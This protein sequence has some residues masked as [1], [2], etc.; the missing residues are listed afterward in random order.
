MNRWVSRM[1]VTNAPT[2]NSPV[3]IRAPSVDDPEPADDE[4]D[5]E[6]D[7][8]EEPQRREERDPR[9]DGVPVGVE[10]VA[11]GVLDALGLVGLGVRGLDD[12]DA[13]EVV[14]E[15]GVQRADGGPNL[16][17]L[18]L[19]GLYETVGE[20]R[21]EG[22]GEQRDERQLPVE[23]GED[24]RDGEHHHQQPEE[25]VHPVVEERLQPVDVVREHGHHLAGLLVGE[26]GHVEPLHPVVGVGPDGVL[27]VLGEGVPPPVP[28]PVERRAAEEARDDQPRGEPEL[29]AG[30]CREPGPRHQRQVEGLRP[31]D[32]RV[33]GD[34]EEQ[35]REQVEHPGGHARGQPDGEVARVG[36]AVLGEQPEHRV[37]HPLPLV[38]E[39]VLAHV[40]LC[41]CHC[42][43]RARDAR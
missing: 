20:V 16:G 17:V 2:E 19:D 8:R 5:H 7:P 39:G 31:L 14:L 9:R 10:V 33:D 40:D 41:G 36:P 4:R 34:A 29:R 35:W 1:K 18:R 25:G 30:V 42:L 38:L 28:A 24:R 26:E 22:D 32:D 12:A 13:A 21:D 11:G 15:P 6:A 3:K 43:L 23:V 37:V 27:D